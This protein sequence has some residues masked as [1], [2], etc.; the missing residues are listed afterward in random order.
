MM[1]TKLI[2]IRK[3]KMFITMLMTMICQE[4]PEY[5]LFL[6]YV[7]LYWVLIK[8]GVLKPLNLLASHNKRPT[9]QSLYYK[10]TIWCQN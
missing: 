1:N 5:L 4:K 2:M 9:A 6:Q 10:S 3:S 8:S 7:Q